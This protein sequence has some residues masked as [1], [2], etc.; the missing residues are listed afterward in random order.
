MRERIRLRSVALVLALVTLVA[1]L[2]LSSSE[3]EALR[4]LLTKSCY[5]GGLEFTNG[6]CRDGQRCVTGSGDVD[7]WQDDDNCPQV[8]SGPGGRRQV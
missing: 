5:Y 7:Y 8:S 4:S 6:A 2:A 1:G 3:A